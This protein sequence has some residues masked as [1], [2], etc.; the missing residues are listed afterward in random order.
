VAALAAQGAQ[1]ESTEGRIGVSAQNVTI[2]EA[3]QQTLDLDSQRTQRGKTKG[4]REVETSRDSAVGSTFSGQDG[5]TVIA[6][7]GNITATA[8]TL[9]SEQGAVALTAKQDITLNSATERES[10]YV[11]ERSQKKGFL[12]KS[13]SHSVK[14]D[15]TTREQGTLLS[16]DTVSVKAG[17]DLLASGSAIVGTATLICKPVIA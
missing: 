6:Q 1:V 8:S 17:N 11:E 3:R 16:G 4:Q 13:S 7:E 10:Q 9:H 15:S 5:V 2:E 14:L 12:K